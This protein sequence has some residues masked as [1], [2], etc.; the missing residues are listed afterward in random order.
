V[1]RESRQLQSSND[2]A[3]AHLCAGVQQ[4]TIMHAAALLSHQALL[5]LQA[6]FD[7]GQPDLGTLSIMDKDRGDI[8]DYYTPVY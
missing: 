5:F 6:K 7:P 2:A 1:H 3:A 8:D 4:R